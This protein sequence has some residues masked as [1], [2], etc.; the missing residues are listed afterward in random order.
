MLRSGFTSCPLCMKHLRYSELHDQISFL[1]EDSLLNAAEQVTNATRSTII[2][3]FHIV[4]VMYSDVEHTPHNVAWGHAIC[5][6]KLG[7]RKCYPLSEL[8]SH[9]SKV[10]TVNQEGLIST[11][12]WISKNL[13]MIRSPAGA[14]WIR[15][16][17]DHL[18]G[19]DQARLFEF[20]EAYRGE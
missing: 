17:H 3:L 6:T 7:Q 11:F 4:P 5:N 14:V 9:G 13:E 15:I 18:S 20:L 19:D 8:I 16:V 12:G 2:N 10:G 1:D